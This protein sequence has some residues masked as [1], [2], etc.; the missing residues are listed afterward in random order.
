MELATSLAM[1][2]EI[3]MLGA[4]FIRSSGLIG[5][6]PSFQHSSGEGQE[7]GGAYSSLSMVL[8][9]DLCSWWLCSFFCPLNIGEREERER[10]RGGEREKE[11]E[12]DT[13]GETLLFWH[14]LQV[15]AVTKKENCF[16]V[17]SQESAYSPFASPSTRLSACGFVTFK[18]LCWD[19]ALPSPWFEENI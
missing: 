8:K 10:K 15:I 17:E 11:T 9:W 16:L 19:M 7:V 14:D 6:C 5:C 18:F 2:S 1:L 4:K 13:T 12:T 3:S